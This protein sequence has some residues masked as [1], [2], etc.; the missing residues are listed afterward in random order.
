[1]ASPDPDLKSLFCEALE[2][3]GG[4]ER[5]AYL[6]DACRGN[7]ALK[8]GVEELLAAHDQADRFL[9]QGP[10]G[11]VTDGLKTLAVTGP[12]APSIATNAA[13][14]IAAETPESATTSAPETLA[15]AEN[16]SG[17]RIL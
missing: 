5:E 8:A 17:A 12:H 16:G 9:A 11:P 2:R 3:P 4:P 7:Q 13:E 10:K 1:M 15:F 6:E 14:T